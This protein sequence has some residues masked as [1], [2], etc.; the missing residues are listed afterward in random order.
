MRLS[1]DY[2]WLVAAVVAAALG[3]HG[4]ALAPSAPLAPRPL[5]APAAG[6]DTLTPSADTYVAS[7]VPI[8]T[9]GP[10]TRWNRAVTPTGTSAPS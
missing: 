2:R 5:L 6:S 8:R 4:D 1:P 10:A 9:T 7:D 3:C